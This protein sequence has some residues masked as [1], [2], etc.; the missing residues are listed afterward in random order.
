MAQYVL[1]SWAVRHTV[2]RNFITEGPLIFVLLTLH[3][4]DQTVNIVT[5]GCRVA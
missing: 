3:T 4:A 1:F 2:G 5:Q